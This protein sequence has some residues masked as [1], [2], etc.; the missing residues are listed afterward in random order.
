MLND[1]N[2]LIPQDPPD[3]NNA[4]GQA[5]FVYPAK[6]VKPVKKTNVWLKSITSLALYLLIGYYFCNQVQTLGLCSR[7][8]DSA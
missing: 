7:K 6:P 2:H 5:G 3:E 4:S 1:N 8:S